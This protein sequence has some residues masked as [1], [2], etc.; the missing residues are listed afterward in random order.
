MLPMSLR[1]ARPFARAL[2]DTMLVAALSAGGVAAIHAQGQ[3][4]PAAPASAVP[5]RPAKAEQ[6]PAWST[7]KPAQREALKPLERDWASID[8]LGKRKWIEIAARFPSM[9]AKDQARLQARM[10]EWARLTPLERGQVRLHY[11]EAKQVPPQERQASWEAYQALPPEQRRELAERAAPPASASASGHTKAAA[12]A[13]SAA[14]STGQRPRDPL[15]AKVNTVSDPALAT[16]PK[17][18]APTVVQAGPGAT[19]TLISKP[20]TPP[21]HQQSGMPKIAATPEYVDKKTLLPQAG[22]QSARAAAASAPS[23]TPR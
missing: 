1:A 19:T 20:Q 11:Q 5:V 10:T 6:G 12:R 14:A 16:R 23:S 22:A 9:P 4:K 8:A 13:A 18:V 7:L 3:T 2:R 15:P 21:A 17:P